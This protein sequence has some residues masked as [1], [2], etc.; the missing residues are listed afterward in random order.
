MLP[1][2]NT[3][4]GFA[5]RTR[6]N[7][8]A[9]NHA[10]QKGVLKDVHPVTQLVNSLLGLVVVPKERRPKYELWTTPW[11]KLQSDKWPEWEWKH[12][13]NCNREG[14]CHELKHFIGHL[15]NA[16]AHGRFSFE[17][18]EDSHDL[19]KVVFVVEDKSMGSTEINWRAS[20][21]CDKLLAFCLKLSEAIDHQQSQEA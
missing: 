1:R 16:A 11:E 15:R 4:K 7:L 8:E 6:R 14:S 10:Y 13:G 17:G 9:F 2:R 21:R 18:C 5:G 19:Q 3:T 12:I 20:I